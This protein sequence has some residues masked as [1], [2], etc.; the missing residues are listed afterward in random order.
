M[1]LLYLALFK[2]GPCTWHSSNMVLVPGTPQTWSLYQALLKHGPCTWDSSNMVLVPDTPR[3]WSLYL[4]L[5]EHGPVWSGG[6][7]LGH[8]VSH[9]GVQAD[10]HIYLLQRQKE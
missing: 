1:V 3:T 4:A 2:H 5:L 6:S 8:L 9:P 7:V 10:L